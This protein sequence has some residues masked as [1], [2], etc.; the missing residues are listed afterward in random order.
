MYYVL[1][2]TWI[3]LSNLNY[4]LTS[5]RSTVAQLSN[6][7]PFLM[8]QGYSL[9]EVEKPVFSVPVTT[10]YVVYRVARDKYKL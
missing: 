4:G 9:P 8:E 2:I 3:I 1:Y 6:E 5:V 10:R 7:F